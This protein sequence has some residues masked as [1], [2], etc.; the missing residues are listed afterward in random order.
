MPAGPVAWVTRRIGLPAP[1]RRFFSNRPRQRDQKDQKDGRDWHRF[2]FRFHFSRCRK[3]APSVAP[4]AEGLSDHAT[5]VSSAVGASVASIYPTLSASQILNHEADDRHQT[6][7]NTNRIKSYGVTLLV[8]G[9]IS[10]ASTEVQAQTN[11][12]T[13][14]TNTTSTTTDVLG[15][16]GLSSSIVTTL[17]T[18][19]IESA[20]N[21]AVAPYLTYSSAAANHVGVKGS[22]L[23]NR[24][25][26]EWGRILGFGNGAKVENRVSGSLVPS[27]SAKATAG[28]VS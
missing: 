15:L 24:S 20:T 2:H 9:L 12:T 17:E 19:G 14:D 6:Q 13:T 18:S 1:V 3:Y 16:L 4:G 27:L 7:M 10:V 22:A 25:L 11:T 26:Q 21:W 23:T 5:L 28:Q 8:A